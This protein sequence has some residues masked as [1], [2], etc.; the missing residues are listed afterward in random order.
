M[1]DA[2]ALFEEV[3][4]MARRTRP[5]TSNRAR[6]K[7][8]PIASSEASAPVRKPSKAPLMEPFYLAVDRQLKSGHDTYEAAEKAA[9]AIKKRH[10][11]LYVTVYD[12]KNQRHTLVEQPKQAAVANKK[13]TPP[14]ARNAPERRHVSVA[15]AKH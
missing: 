5:S 8:T 13:P 4:A 12:A 6:Q 10:P 3:K 7:R 11:R 9:L 2:I 14:A 15:G 1:A